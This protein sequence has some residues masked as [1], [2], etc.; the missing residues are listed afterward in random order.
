M[1]LL[2]S[3]PWCPSLLLGDCCAQRSS[4]QDLLTQNPVS[5]IINSSKAM[6]DFRC[7]TAVR[8]RVASVS[9]GCRGSNLGWCEG[10]QVP[11]LPSKISLFWAFVQRSHALKQFSALHCAI[12]SFLHPQGHLSLEEGCV[13]HVWMFSTSSL[14]PSVLSIAWGLV[15]HSAPY[16]MLSEYLM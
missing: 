7:V 12:L 6:R 3:W 16:K 10:S 14:H 11:V 8:M 9:Q 4:G 1:A 15:A 13:W 2:Y 5:S